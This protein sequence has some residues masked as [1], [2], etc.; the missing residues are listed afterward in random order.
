[1]KHLSNETKLDIFK[2]LDFN[3]LC[4]VR[5]TNRHFNALIEDYK[6]E[7]AINNVSPM[8]L[9][10]FMANFMELPLKRLNDR[11]HVTDKQYENFSKGI[12]GI[13][14]RITHFGQRGKTYRVVEVPHFPAEKLTFPYQAY[15]S[16]HITLR[17]VAQHFITQYNKHLKYPHLPC[18]RV[19]HKLQHMY[20]PVEV[21]EILPGQRC[22]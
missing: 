12:N 2:F 10:N 18:I 13:T 15:R 3:K 22:S 8:P 5:Q 19:E 4:I 11:I 14:I 17:T 6:K 7:L 1:M 16:T 9:L 20:F 21:C